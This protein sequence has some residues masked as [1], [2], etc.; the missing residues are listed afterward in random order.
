MVNGVAKAVVL[1]ARAAPVEA[2]IAYLFTVVGHVKVGTASVDA[3]KVI[4]WKQ[5]T[6]NSESN[7][8]LEWMRAL[9]T[10]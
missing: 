4:R 10:A 1:A 2:A 6:Q 9:G 7:S 3:V 5:G 8:L